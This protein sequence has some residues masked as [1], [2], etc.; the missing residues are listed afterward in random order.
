MTADI[1][2]SLSE[3]LRKANRLMT[4]IDELRQFIRTIEGY[5]SDLIPPLSFSHTTTI[6]MPKD[7]YQ[8]LKKDLIAHYQ[9]R[10]D[11]LSGELLKLLLPNDI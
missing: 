6:V 5:R 8:K 1:F 4:E 11:E 7:V 9:A 2:L 3:S 10:V